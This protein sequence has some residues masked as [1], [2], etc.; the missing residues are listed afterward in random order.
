MS[1]KKV[2]VKDNVKYGWKLVTM[3]PSNYIWFKEEERYERT[4][5]ERWEELDFN[6]NFND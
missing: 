5:G 6:I 3:N 4:Y 2:I 1:T